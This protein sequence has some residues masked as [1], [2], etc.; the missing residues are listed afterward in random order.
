MI[1]F[2][3][4]ATI[5]TDWSDEIVAITQNIEM[6]TG[7]F[8]RINQRLDG[9]EKTLAELSTASQNYTAQD[10]VKTLTDLRKTI[11]QLRETQFPSYIMPD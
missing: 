10:G 4:M 1:L 7:S 2:L 6:L 11:G 8:Q 5:P 3:A 9:I